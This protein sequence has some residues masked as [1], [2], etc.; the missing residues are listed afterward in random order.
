MLKVGDYTRSDWGLAR[1]VEV[2][3][4]SVTV[5]VVEGPDKGERINQM[6]G[7]PGADRLAL[8]K[9]EG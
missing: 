7:T 9:V 4:R 3:G 6:R 2:T 8:A 1:V 5:E